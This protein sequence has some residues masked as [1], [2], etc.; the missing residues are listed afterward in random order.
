MLP[1]AVNRRFDIATLQSGL[2][3]PSWWEPMP[4]RHIGEL[5]HSFLH[6]LIRALAG[7][8]RGPFR[9]HGLATHAA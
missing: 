4:N 9:Y 6:P 8:S 1:Q 5:S 7:L 3:L 2:A